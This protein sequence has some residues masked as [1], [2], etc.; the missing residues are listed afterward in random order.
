MPNE[1]HY[2]ISNNHASIVNIVMHDVPTLDVRS[3]ALRITI[4][5]L[6]SG[7]IV[8]SCDGSVC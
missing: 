4:K 6:F 1:L 2:H 7:G 5:I 8:P 3:L